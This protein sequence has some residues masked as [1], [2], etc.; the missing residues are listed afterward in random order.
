MNFYNDMYTSYCEYKETHPEEYVSIDRIDNNKGYYKENC[1]WAGRDIQQNNK[2]TNVRYNYN[3]KDYTVPEIIATGIPDSD[4][5]YDRIKNNIARGKDI[6]DAILSPERKNVVN[7]VSF[8]D[9]NGNRI[10]D[11]C[12]SRHDDLHE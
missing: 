9:E 4:R 10:Q 11:P 7:P 3:G 8:Y 12:N 2:R 6:K 5:N 1:R